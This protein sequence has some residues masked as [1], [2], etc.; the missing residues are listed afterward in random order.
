MKKK[1][2]T[3]LGEATRQFFAKLIISL[4]FKQSTIQ[5][6]LHRSVLSS[7]F[8]SPFNFLFPESSCTPH[9]PLPRPGGFSSHLTLFLICLFIFTT[10]HVT[11]RHAL[12]RFTHTAAVYLY[13]YRCICFSLYPFICLS[14]RL[15]I[16]LYICILLY[17]RL[18]VSCVQCKQL[19]LT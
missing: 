2:G 3:V 8:S 18:S 4:L 7:T 19:Q 5:K 16:Y 10:F 15:S 11:T 12:I 1:G 17:V 14:V 6:E 13:I 9:S